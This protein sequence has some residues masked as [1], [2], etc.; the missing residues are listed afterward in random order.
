MIHVSKILVIPFTKNHLFIH[1][2]WV[3]WMEFELYLGEHV[4]EK[5]MNQLRV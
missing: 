4:L 5:Q 2:T 1:L 3:N